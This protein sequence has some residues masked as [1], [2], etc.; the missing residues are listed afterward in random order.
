LLKRY[1][2]SLDGLSHGMKCS[3]TI[4]TRC[5]TTIGKNTGQTKGEKT[6]NRHYL[7]IGGKLYSA[8]QADGVNLYPCCLG[9]TPIRDRDEFPWP[10]LEAKNRDTVTMFGER[11][12]V[13]CLPTDGTC[14]DEI[15]LEMVLLCRPGDPEG[16]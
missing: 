4:T 10:C 16:E 12:E 2:W 9:V 13:N 3:G 14:E 5:W 7:L 15:D 8:A 6:M 11:Y 1:L